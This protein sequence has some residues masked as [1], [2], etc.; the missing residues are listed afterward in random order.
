MPTSFTPGKMPTLMNAREAF[1]AYLDGHD[2][3]DVC[4]LPDRTAWWRQLPKDHRVAWLT[5]MLWND[6]DLVPFHYVAQLDLPR[7]TTYAHAARHIREQ[8]GRSSD[9]RPS[10]SGTHEAAMVQLRHSPRR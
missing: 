3:A 10:V 5:G 1:L 2:L 9:Q 4:W 7:G 6:D 8:L